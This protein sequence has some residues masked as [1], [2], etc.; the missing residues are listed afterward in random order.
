MEKER[1]VEIQTDDFPEVF[2]SS[3]PEIVPFE[4]ETHL[5]PIKPEKS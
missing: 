3:H 2:P 5:D 1:K 4:T